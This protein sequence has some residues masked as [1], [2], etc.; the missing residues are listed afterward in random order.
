[1]DEILELGI[2]ELTFIGPEIEVG[3]RH[4]DLGVG[5]VAA[6]VVGHQAPAVVG[7]RMGEND[8]IDVLRV[9][10]G[11]F[12]TRDKSAAIRAARLGG[13]GPSA[14]E[15]RRVDAAPGCV[16]ESIAVVEEAQVTAQRGRRSG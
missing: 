12:E 8:R 13:A 10:T 2:R 16:Q 4:V 9:E 6:A 14:L 15:D 5:K 11:G 3:L 1:G 7:M